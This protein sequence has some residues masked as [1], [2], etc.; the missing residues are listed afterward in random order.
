[1][2]KI[3]LIV[4][5]ALALLAVPAV[6]SAAGAN[7]ANHSNHGKTCKKGF[8]RNGKKCVKNRRHSVS[9]PGPQGSVGPAGPQ[10]PQGTPGINGNEGKEG[11]KGSEGSR[12]PT[13][14]TGP[15]GSQ[16]PE[17]EQGTEGKQGNEGPKG[18]EGPT[19]APGAPGPTGPEGPEGPQGP[20][21]PVS[22]IT[23]NN[24]EPSSFIDNPVSLGYAA[25]GTTE[26]GS[27]IVQTEEA[28]DAEVEVLMSVWSCEQGGGA[29]CV[30]AD[31]AATFAAPLTLNVY[32]VT[33]E[34]KVG[35]LLKSVT[36]MFNLPYRPTTDPS[37]P[38]GTSF[39]AADGHCQHG[40]P[41]PVDF[42]TGVNLPRKIIISV[43]FTPSNTAGDPLNSL[44][45]GLEGPPSVGQNPLETNNWVYWNSAW[46][47]EKNS[48]SFHLDTTPNE[49]SIGESQIA[50]TI[51]NG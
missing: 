17:G 40:Y 30:T 50:A 18:K 32:A 4:V 42:E 43:S 19:G 37:C 48:A 13:G 10:G 25:T 7:Q 21:A 39:K 5:V 6:A 46:F 23:Y 41:V 26:F 36:N 49:W 27:Q 11:P 22:P 38:D 15:V 3:T 24:I 2:R 9:I 20:P 28:T 34:N 1:M 31:P 45:V 35:A 12:G 47:G 33:Y 16:G 14:S 44:N 8:H 29:T 51:S